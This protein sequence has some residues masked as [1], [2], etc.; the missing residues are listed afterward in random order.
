MLELL[1]LRDRRERLEPRRLEID[2]S[3]ADTVRDIIRRVRDEGDACLVELALRFDGADL[4]E[5]GLVATPNEFELAQER[6][7]EDLAAA[8]DALVERLTDLHARQLPPEWWDEGRGLRFGE[9]V[10]P[11]S[12]AGCYVPGGRALYPSSVAM[13]V[14]PAVVAGVGEI[15][16]CTPARPDG[17]LPPAV[18]YAAA[19]SGATRVVKT[20]GAQAIAALAYGTESVPRADVIAGPG[21]LYVQ[22]AKR[23][24]SGDVGIDG[25]AGPSDVLVLASEGGDPALVAIDLAAQA[26]HGEGT[27][28]CAVSDDPALLDAIAFDPGQAAAAQPDPRPSFHV[29]ET[30]P[31]SSGLFFAASPPSILRRWLYRYPSARTP[32]RRASCAA[33][34][35][36]RTLS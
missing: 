17:S 11:I 8:I 27:I 23:L 28:V 19:R 10:R 12:A 2:P 3:L 35:S 25:F 30:G 1:D 14:V 34:R 15:V 24:V 7:P 9:M 5:T 33:R 36:T 21:N 32:L 20:G 31:C 29:L 13:T 26:E 6:I 18:L 22:E 4:R 16:V